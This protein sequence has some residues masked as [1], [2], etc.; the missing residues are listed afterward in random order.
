MTAAPSQEVIN[1]FVVASHFDMPKVREMLEKQPLLLNE[2]AEWIETPVQAAAHVGNREIA[3]FLLAKG[4]P[5]DICTAAMLGQVDTV[6]SMLA[7]DPELKDATGAHNLG[8]LFYPAIAGNMEIAEI[9]YAAGASVN[10]GGSQ[11][12]LIGAI[13]GKHLDMVRWL[14]DHDADP[15]ATDFNGRTALDVAEAND[16]GEAADLLRPYYEDAESEEAAADES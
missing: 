13:V 10:P 7:A 11:S 12:P 9:L 3:E 6:K 5:L 14:L 4:A 15:Y 2:N 1:E 8:V 16:F